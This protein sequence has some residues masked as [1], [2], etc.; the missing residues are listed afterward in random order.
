MGR[1]YQRAAEAQQADTQER[2]E[3]SPL[4]GS[5]V[6]AYKGV[7]QP[8]STFTGLIQALWRVIKMPFTSKEQKQQAAAKIKELTAAQSKQA[9]VLGPIIER[10]TE[11]L[12]GSGNTMGDLVKAA[13]NYAE[14]PRLPSHLAKELGIDQNKVSFGDKLRGYITGM[15]PK[16]I[17][18]TRRGA[19]SV[20]DLVRKMQ[21]WGLVGA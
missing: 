14:E 6:A 7:S 19:K 11:E 20:A 18:A 13:V 8:A 5:A 12:G 4:T 9:S 1:E 10:A 16:D 2:L 17:K 21:E 15:D 3:S